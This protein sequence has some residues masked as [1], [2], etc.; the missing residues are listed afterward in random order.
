MVPLAAD[1]APLSNGGA[2]RPNGGAPVR[3]SGVP[4]SHTVAPEPN[5][6][7]SATIGMGTPTMQQVS[8]T[9]QQE[10]GGC[11]HG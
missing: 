3:D 9:A 6:G 1:S 5:I 4:V 2:P 8:R 11:R 10:T 7:E